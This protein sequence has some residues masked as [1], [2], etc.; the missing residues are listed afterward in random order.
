MHVNMTMCVDRGG[1][2][3]RKARHWIMEGEKGSEG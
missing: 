2:E 3:E 1:K